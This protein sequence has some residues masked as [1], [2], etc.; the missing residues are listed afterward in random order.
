[1]SEYVSKALTYETKDIIFRYSMLNTAHFCLT[2]AKLQYLDKIPEP[3]L[4][5]AYFAFG[6][7]LH[8]GL[9]NFVQGEDG[10]EIFR[11][12]WKNLKVGEYDWKFSRDSY[13]TLGSIAD[14]LLRK[15][16][17]GHL[18]H[19]D[20]LHTELPLRG[21][22]NGFT[23]TGTAD[24]VGLYKGV[25][26]IVDWKTSQSQYDKRKGQVDAQMWIYAELLKQQ[27]GLEVKQLV[28]SPFVKYGS[29]VQTPIAI[30]YTTIK[31]KSMLDNATLVMRDLN[32]R[33]E[34]P[35]NEQNCL[36]CNY[37]PVCYKEDK[38]ENK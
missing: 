3:G 17:K 10:A 14:E 20:A 9:E 27:Y 16:E 7:G 11:L 22:I 8:L 19:Y 26:S 1:M 35:R 4:R 30:P 38:D 21:T 32:G 24:F 29:V 18:K 25:L 2:K 36:R 34:W 37:Y 5:G 31:A 6:T 12:F 33:V 28:Y 15:F 23:V 13:D